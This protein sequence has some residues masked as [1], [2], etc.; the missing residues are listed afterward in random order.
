MMAAQPAGLHWLAWPLALPAE[1]AAPPATAQHMRS[2]T[3]PAAAQKL[4]QAMQAWWALRWSPK[5]AV[6]DDVVWMET[7]SVERLWG[8]RAALIQQLQ[9]QWRQER[10]PQEQDAPLAWAQ[11]PTAWQALARLRCQQRVLRLRPGAAEPPAPR[12]DALPLWTLPGLQPHLALLQRMGCRR[13]GDVRALPRA[14]LAERIG[15]AALLALDQAYGE[16]VH[17]VDWLSLPLHFSLHEDLAWSVSDSTALLQAARPLLQ[18]M[19]AWLRGHHQGVLALRLSWHHS[20]RRLDGQALPAWDALELRTAEPAQALVHIERLLAERLE[21][22]PW[23]APVDAL[24]L[25]TLETAPWLDGRAHDW[26]AES[27]GPAAHGNGQAG[28]GMAWHEWAERVSQRLGA[29]SVLAPQPQADH[30]PEAMQQ[31][32][33]AVLPRG[34]SPG[35][36]LPQDGKD[37][38]QALWPA[39]LLPQPLALTLQGSRPCWHGPLQLLAGP[40]RL[41][42]GWWGHGLADPNQAQAMAL[43]DPLV[44]RDYFVAHNAVV[45]HVWV[46]RQRLPAPDA[47]QAEPGQWPGASAMAHGWFAQGVYG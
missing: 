8:G 45:G 26:I 16:A 38:W 41:E 43:P 37:P 28:Q 7:S 17:S 4:Q 24:A 6:W 19:Q 3:R 12:P 30:R 1:P 40:Y 5:V 11:G 32:A 31:W 23:L 14:G 47:E 2:S 33:Q 18:A 44:V 25:Q 20:L 46:F 15:R 21:R 42:S 34:R 13:W 27:G 36:E 35:L 22:R 39:W 10:A 9:Q 29:D